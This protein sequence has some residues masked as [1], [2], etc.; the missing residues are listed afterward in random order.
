MRDGIFLYMKGLQIALANRMAYRG[1]F[2]ISFVIMLLSEMLAP[3]ITLLIYANG[4]VFPGWRFEEVLLIQGV[5]ML[6][7][8][9]GFVLFFGMVGETLTLVRDGNFDLMLMKPRPVLLM[10]AVNS[11]DIQQISRVVTGLMI[12]AYALSLM[13]RPSPLAWISFSSLLVLSLIVMLAFS[14]MMASTVIKWVGNG[15]VFEIFDAVVNFGMYPKTIFSQAFAN[16]ITFVVPILLIGFAPAS[17][18]MGR[19]VEGILSSFIAAILFLM[20]SLALWHGM[21]RFYTSAGG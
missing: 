7:R 14:I 9:I 20:A 8:G 3:I 10:A 13:D 15:R 12:S 21:M 19:E 17:V 16:L 2:F 4:A 5:F 11:I 18:L 6:S 1:D